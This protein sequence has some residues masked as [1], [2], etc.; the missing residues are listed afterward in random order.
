M[1][2][3]VV[4]NTPTEQRETAMAA[5]AAKIKDID[6]DIG[7]LKMV[8]YGRNGQGKT[9]FAGS[10]DL[11]TL[12]VDCDEK[13]WETL[14]DRPNVKRYELV[15]WE[16]LEGLFWLLKTGKHPWMPEV[17][18]IDTVTMLSNVCIR[19]LMGAETN[20]NPIRPEWD[21]WNQLSQTMSNEIIRWRNLPMHVLFLAQERN[22]NVRNDEGDEL[23]QMIAPAVTPSVL[24]TLMGAVG[25]IGRISAN[26]IEREAEGDEKPKKF[27]Q[28]QMLLGPHPVYQAKSRIRGVPRVFKSPTL[29]KL[30]ALREAGGE[31]KPGQ[32]VERDGQ[33]A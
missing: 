20:L 28:Y 19:A 4:S 22:I 9:H 31:V 14:R 30:L 29:A 1:A 6:E 7:P 16:E 26:V 2:T 27:I 24:A 33:A 25:T 8:V 13:G 11:R 32:A 15:K 23:L 21:S 17:V 5:A 3:R 18:A 12:I 10:S